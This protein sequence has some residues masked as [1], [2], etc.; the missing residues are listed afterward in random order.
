M[1]LPAI[2]FMT[3]SVGFV[4]GLCAWCYWKVL[5]APEVPE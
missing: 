1:T 2:V 5:S 4:T 3:L